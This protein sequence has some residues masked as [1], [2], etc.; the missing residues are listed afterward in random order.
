MTKLIRRW[1][2]VNT[3]SA[4]RRRTGADAADAAHGGPGQ[5]PAAAR[6]TALVRPGPAASVTA[7]D[8]AAGR[9]A[10]GVRAGRQ[11]GRGADHGE[12]AD[13]RPEPQGGAGAPRGRGRPA[14]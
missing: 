14:A 8:P 10:D 12:P 5:T 9:P 4:G 11:A 6:A 7:V 13:R 1:A 2:G 3:R